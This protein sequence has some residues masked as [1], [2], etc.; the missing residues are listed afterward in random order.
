M[1]FST[2]TTDAGVIAGPDHGLRRLIVSVLSVAP[3]DVG[4]LHRH[5]GDQILIVVRGA[6]LVE[7]DGEARICREGEL[8]VAP[9]GATHGFRGLGG[10]AR[11][12]VVGEQRCGT[13]FLLNDG[14]AVEVHRPGVPWDRPGPATDMAAL[15]PRLVAP[16]LG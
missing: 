10:P 15:A 8:G 12:E 3:D 11:L 6:V 14:G 4:W 16:R 9:A 7:V 5:E 13:E 2:R 1:R